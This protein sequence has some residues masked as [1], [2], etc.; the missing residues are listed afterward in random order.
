MPVVND[1]SDISQLQFPEISVQGDSDSNY[2]YKYYNEQ[3]IGPILHFR[4]LYIKRS[5]RE[6]I[7][8]IGAIQRGEFSAQ[9]FEEMSRYHG[10]SRRPIKKYKK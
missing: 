9:L 6:N 10:D 1:S 8:M 4:D 3:L 5:A 7:I 2:G